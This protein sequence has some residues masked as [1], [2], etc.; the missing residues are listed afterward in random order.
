MIFNIQPPQ[1]AFE[2]SLESALS[3]GPFDVS[4][5][6]LKSFDTVPALEG[7]KKFCQPIAA[8]PVPAKWSG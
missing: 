2:P 1:V 4:L 7:M 8:R 3:R 6:A 5:F